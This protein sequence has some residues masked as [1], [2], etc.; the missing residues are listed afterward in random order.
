MGSMGF[1]EMLS[2]VFGGLST[3][4]SRPMSGKDEGSD[5]LKNL[6]WQAR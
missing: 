4:F 6:Y 1:A 5:L 3:V 2:V